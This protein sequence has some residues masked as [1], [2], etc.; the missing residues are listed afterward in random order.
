MSVNPP[1]LA[2]ATKLE[3]KVHQGKNI[4]WEMPII[5]I[6]D[7]L[8]VD[9]TGAA[10]IFTVK[11]KVSDASALITRSVGNGIVID[12]D[13]VNNKGKFQLSL[14]PTNTD[15]DLGTYQM[16]IQITLFGKEQTPA[17]G[18][19]EILDVVTNL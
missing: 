16:D 18:T 19:F 7:G 3:L 9:I 17:R 5:N 6:Q 2:I 13:Q 1:D 14:I 11:S 15:K 4:T 10:I 8:A 12:L